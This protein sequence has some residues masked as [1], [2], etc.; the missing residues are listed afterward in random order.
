MS[1][2]MMRPPRVRQ[3]RLDCPA[4]LGS[5][6]GQEARVPMTPA[7]PLA[8]PV[9]AQDSEPALASPPRT[10]NVGAMTNSA[11]AITP[12]PDDLE[13]IVVLDDEVAG[14]LT[15]SATAQAYLRAQGIMDPATWQALRV[16]AVADSDLTR[17]LTPRQRAHL[18]PQG[19][20]LPTF[21]PR[22]PQRIIG[23]IR[24]SPSQNQH[25][26]VSAPAGLASPSDLNQHARVVLCDHP[27]RAMRLYER[28]VRGI[29]IVEDPAVLLPLTAWLSAR[30]VVTITTAKRGELSLPPSITPVGTGRICG[31]LEQAS[32]QTL[33]LLG[34]DAAALRPSLT[35]L[36]LSP[37][38][39]RDLHAYAERQLHTEVGMA[40]LARFGYDQP[41]VLR[42]YRIG[43]LSADFRQALSD[44]HRRML[45]GRNLGGCLVLPAFDAQGAVVDLV[46]LQACAG[47]SVLPTLWDVP[48]G[49]CA[50]TLATSCDRVVV[51]TVPVWV[52]RLFRTVGPT[53]L[54]RGVDNARTE[55]TRLATG[56][57]TQVEVRCRTHAESVGIADSLRA[58]G[59]TVRVVTDESQRRP[60]AGV[61]AVTSA[62]HAVP[63][64]TAL[65]PDPLPVAAREPV[66]APPITPTLEL[67]SH[68]AQTEQAIFRYGPAT[69]AVQVPWGSRT[70]AEVVLTVGTA[71]HRDRFDLAIVAQRLR[72]AA[73]ASLRTTVPPADIAAALALILP[74]VQRFAAPATTAAVAAPTPTPTGMSSAEREAALSLLRAPDLLPR[75]LADLDALGWVGEAEAKTVVLLAAISR[76]S[77]E[78]V[79]AMLTADAPSERFPALRILAAI[80]PPEQCLHLSRLTDSALFHGGADALRH[81]LLILDD[82]AGVGTAVATALRVLQARGVLTATQVERDPVRGGMRTRVVEA[83][84]PVA[85]LTATSASVPAALASQFVDVALDESP[86]QAERLLAARQRVTTPTD[87]E[88]LATRW[89]TAQRLLRALPVTI[90]SDVAIPAIISRHRALHAPFVGFVCASALLHQYQRP[91]IDG[92]VIATAADVDLARRAVAPLAT[93]VVGSLTARAQAAMTAL[94]GLSSTTFT[95]ADL[96]RL[97]PDWSR[98]TA[99]RAVEDLLAAD[100]AVA[101]RQRSGVRAQYQLMASPI[102][103]SDLL[104]CSGPAQPAWAGATREVVNG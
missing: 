5:V 31:K 78:P 67:V 24:L 71:K 104:T 41:D 79:W 44:D 83:R 73:T 47:G 102:P 80:T 38:V 53:L 58:V 9:P 15:L 4:S 96:R 76:L 86:A 81:K 56:G 20:W 52:G 88:R 61:M 2:G 90:P 63:V 60:H 98:G 21:D 87:R 39:V 54:L 8:F 19:L 11:A 66:P 101:L 22:E 68:D 18:L 103:R 30:E 64:P 7:G 91:L 29:A 26:F 62:D 92:R 70:S 16:D 12:E 23:L 48:R 10:P 43:Y 28:G 50:P 93:Q 51:T 95:L 14:S 27:L 36:P 100:Y 49:M 34:L 40:A 1:T 69:Y 45:L 33:A 94:S 89:I 25:R 84:G 57:V 65:V 17:L 72:F 6:C 32:A 13:P 75:L 59:M 74:A 82:L 46:A 35:A 37:L 55:A 3:V 85:V 97:V 42:A 77:D 99:C